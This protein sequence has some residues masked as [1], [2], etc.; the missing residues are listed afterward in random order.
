MLHNE[1]GFD[2]EDGKTYKEQR[3]L[4]F[5]YEN[6]TGIILDGTAAVKYE[7]AE[8]SNNIQDHSD[9]DGL[10]QQLHRKGELKTDLY[11]WEGE[12][13]YPS[14]VDVPDWNGKL[15]PAK[16]SDFDWQNVSSFVAEATGAKNEG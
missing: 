1:R 13:T 8:G 15:R 5:L 6:S 9:L 12:I 16:P 4:L 2:P 7:V 10:M 3:A 14:P 11:V